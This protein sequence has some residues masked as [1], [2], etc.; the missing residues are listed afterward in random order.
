V[1][2]KDETN[3]LEDLEETFETLRQYR[4]KLNP[5]KCVFGGLSGK[6]LGFMVSQR[7]IEANPDKIKAV[8]EMTPPR[9]TKEVQ[10]LTGRVAA[11]NHFISRAT[12]KCLPFFKTLRKAFAWTNKCQKS[13]EELKLYLTSPPLLSPSQQG[14]AL[15]LYLAVSPTAVSSALIRE[16]GGTQLPVYYTSKAFQ[17]A[18]E[19]YPAMEKLAL[20]LVIAARK[21]RPYFQSHK[22]IVLTNDPL[23]KAMNKPDAAG[24]LI[25]WAVELSE[26]DIEY[27]PRQAI[28]AQAL[29]DFIAEFTVTEEEPPEEKPDRNWE[30]EIDRSSVKGA[31]GVGVVF[32][33]PEGHLL[34]HSVWLQYPTTNNEAEYEAL[35][36]GLRIAKE[37]GATR[38]RIQSDSQLIVGQVNGEYE[39][40]EDRMTK[41]LKLVKNAMNWFD[42]VILLQVPREQNTGA[43]AFAKLA[44]SDEATNQHIEVQYSPSHME[45]EVSPIDVSNSWMTPITNYLEGGTLPS[46]PIEARKLRTR[47]ARFALIQGTLYKRGFSLPYLRCLGKA[48]AEYVMREVHEGICGNHSG[49]RSLV[50]KLV[51]A[52][53]YWPTM[54]KDSISY[55]RACDRC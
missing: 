15:S 36:T 41:Y 43:D 11:L 31:G 10:S 27:C 6:F 3:H 47:F 34:K 51:R 22:I 40:K 38:L 49:A 18:E 55:T 39:A 26:F 5:S 35:L 45:E 2:T 37:L 30:V 9:T 25:Q 1:K 42:K 19:R 44:S 33:T 20:A 53:Y 8:L 7:G 24:R 46:D 16:D 14:E 17:G 4:M 28:K 13:F 29:A 54:Q 21:L 12:D 50:H 23:R 52:G 48:E 32:K